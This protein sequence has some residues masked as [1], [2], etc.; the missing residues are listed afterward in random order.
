MFCGGGV[1]NCLSD[2]VS[3]SQHCW[4][5]VNP[6][7]SGC[8]ES[9]QCEAV[10]PGTTC[11]RSGICED[12]TVCV[13]SLIPPACPLPE[14]HNGFPNPATVL[15][16]PSTHPLNL[17]NYMPV[18]CTSTSLET[19]IS[20]GGDGSTWCIYPDGEDDVFI[21]DI[22]NCVSH[23]QVNNEL[24]P[25]YAESVDGICCHNR[26]CNFLLKLVS[27]N[28]SLVSACKRGITEFIPSKY[29]I[30]DEVP[31][32][33]CQST[34]SKCNQEHSC[35]L[36]GSQQA[37]CPTTAHI[38]SAHGGRTYLSKPVENYDR[39]M[40]IAG[41]LPPATI[42]MLNRDVVLISCIMDWGTLTTLSPNRTVKHFAPNVNGYNI[43]CENGNPLRIG[44]EWQRCET[45]TDCPSS[46]SCQG[47]HKVCCPTAQSL[48]TQPK[49]LGDCTSSVRRYW[50]NAA[51][52]QCEMFHYTG[53]QGNDNNFASLVACQQKCRGINGTLMNS[54]E[55][56]KQEMMTVLIE[57]IIKNLYKGFFIIYRTGQSVQL[58]TSAPLTVLLMDAV[59]LKVSKF[60]LNTISLFWSKCSL[61]F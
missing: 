4:P 19:R 48:C 54:V 7:E 60:E 24:F 44:E 53:C 6:G 12:G 50:Y 59:Q 56:V 25:E 35:T 3:I 14:S 5:K 29:A 32:T 42:M 37:C 46:H 22:Y 2:F 30:L 28:I 49:R 1:C 9:R 13:S 20:N 33:N 51:T 36:I 39:G 27:P 31:K 17:G 45:N 16:N 40:L 11:S 8:I 57:S 21:A 47:N 15:A 23:P 61:L 26:V 52:R 58:T 10:W 34:I 41:K 18:L 38:C 55:R 43:V